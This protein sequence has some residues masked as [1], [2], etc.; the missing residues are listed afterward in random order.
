[1]RRKQLF[2]QSDPDA[3]PPHDDSPEAAYFHRELLQELE[4][5][6]NAM[7]PKDKA[8]FIMAELNGLSQTE[9]AEVEGI[10]IGAV[11]SRLFRARAK[12]RSIFAKQRID[13]H[14]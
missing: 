9:I 2:V 4:T 12:L 1:M 8:V 11:K 3:E 14:G 5:A 10:G 6:L 7:P 13:S